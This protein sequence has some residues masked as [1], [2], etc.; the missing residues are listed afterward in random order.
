MVADLFAEVLDGSVRRLPLKRLPQQRIEGLSLAQGL[1]GTEAVVMYNG[2]V[3]ISFRIHL[4]YR[5]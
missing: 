3:I 2:T 5:Y 4:D 1:Q